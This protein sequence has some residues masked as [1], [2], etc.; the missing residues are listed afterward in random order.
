MVWGWGCLRDT[1]G[2]AGGLC[3]AQ[4]VFLGGKGKWIWTPCVWGV[5]LGL[6][7]G[8][9]LRGVLGLGIVLAGGLEVFELW[10]YLRSWF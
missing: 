2:G 4:K 8:L 3:S 7:R 9:W 1:L 5:S 10:S 6:R